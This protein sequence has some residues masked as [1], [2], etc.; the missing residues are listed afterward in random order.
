MKPVIGICADYSY[1]LSGVYEGFGCGFDYQLAANDYVKAVE[2]SGGIPIIIPVFNDNNNVENVVDIVDGIIFAG[3]AD[4]QPKYYGENIGNKIGRIIPERDSQELQLAKNIIE[5]TEIPILGVC[6]GYQLLNVVCGGTLYQDLSEIPMELRNNKII[7]HSMKGSPKYNPVHEVKIN[8]RS[9]FYK[10]FNKKSVEVNSY[11]HQAIKDVAKV[12]DVA[13]VSPDGIIEAIEMKS[14]DRFVVGVQWHPEMLGERNS[15]QLLIF[16][17]L[18]NACK[19]YK[20]VHCA[21]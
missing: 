11:H 10:I 5:K 19:E 3:G 12:F 20:L 7:N 15:E 2:K 8:E 16:K 14:E 4:I 18:V 17:A 1:G 21:S 13:T 9:K 6:R